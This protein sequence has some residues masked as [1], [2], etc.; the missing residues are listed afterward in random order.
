[1]SEPF[2]P[3]ALRQVGHAYNAER[4]YASSKKTS[5]LFSRLK[6]VNTMI[7]ACLQPSGDW[8]PVITTCSF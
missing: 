1:M 5:R 8:L 4:S 7:T 2:G 6:D 3:M